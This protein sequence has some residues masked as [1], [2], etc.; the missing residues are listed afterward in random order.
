MA[1]QLGLSPGS[2]Q[3]A[4]KSWSLRA[5][6]DPFFDLG[7][8]NKITKI[9]R[10]IPHMSDLLMGKYTKTSAADSIQGKS[11]CSGTGIHSNNDQPLGL[12]TDLWTSDDN[13]IFVI[14]IYIYTHTHFL[15][16]YLL[17]YSA[18]LSS[19]RVRTQH[20]FQC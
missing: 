5:G 19:G 9:L 4:P 1:K 15:R 17:H 14:C 8:M 16:V 18:E 12:H 13:W 11:T 2:N 10:W 20:P 6:V 3:T 7:S